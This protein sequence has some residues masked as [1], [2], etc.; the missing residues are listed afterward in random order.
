MS[1]QPKIGQ[2]VPLEAKADQSEALR[3]FLLTGYSLLSGDQEPETLQWYAVKY[4]TP[5]PTYAIID[6]FAAESGRQAHIAGKVAEALMA[7]SDKLLS[8]SPDIPAGAFDILASKIKPLDAQSDVKKGLTIGLR[9]LLK[10][11][12]SQ[13]QAV[14]EFLEGALPLVEAEAQTPVWYAIEFPG[15]NVFGIVDFFAA[16]EGLDLHLKGEVAKALFANVDRLLEGQPDI[17][18]LEVLAVKI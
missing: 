16:Q 11:K 1:T 5:T 18:K 3:Q 14:R 15:M 6:S 7:N 9:V 2:L 4:D 13:V 8:R 10:A 12:E 17:V